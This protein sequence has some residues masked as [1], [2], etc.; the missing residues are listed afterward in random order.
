MIK[1]LNILKRIN[2]K[3]V[4]LLIFLFL[5]RK[6]ENIPTP[7]N[8]YEFRNNTGTSDITDKYNNSITVSPTSD[9]SDSSPLPFSD[10]NGMNFDSDNQQYLSI[11]NFSFGGPHSIELYYK[12]N[13][14]ESESWARLYEFTDGQ[15]DNR[16]NIERY[17]SD[18]YFS[19]GYNEEDT[20]N[21]SVYTNY[22]FIENN[23]WTHLIITLDENQMFKLYKNGSLNMQSFGSRNSNLQMPI[24]QTRTYNLIGAGV[25]SA[26]NPSNFFDGQIAYMKIWQGSVLNQKQVTKLYNNRENK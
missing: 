1:N 8:Y 14:S 25:W 19:I 15:R 11:S 3:I 9:I 23:I 22:N 13:T 10:S 24:T 6:K 7:S 17:D 26:P 21:R 12:M 20:N 2:I 16:V 4:I 18:S 5:V